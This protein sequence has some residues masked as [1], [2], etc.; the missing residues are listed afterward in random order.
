MHE[1]KAVINIKL[2]DDTYSVIED[3]QNS[4]KMNEAMHSYIPDNRNKYE[5]CLY[6]MRNLFH[7][8]A[9]NDDDEHSEEPIYVSLNA[10]NND[11]A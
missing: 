2:K 4:F 9:V 10:L 6:E 3:A 7:Q 8:L 5:S 1:K 11:E